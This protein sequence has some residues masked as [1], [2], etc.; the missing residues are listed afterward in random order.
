MIILPAIDLYNGQAVRL[1]RGD[2][3]NMTVYD[4]EPVNTAM[5]FKASGAEWIHI[6]DLEGAKSGGTPNIRTIIE[7]KRSCSLKCETGGGIRDI[8][9]IERYIESGI[10]RVILGTS[11]VIHE[12]FAAEAVKTFGTEHVAVGVDIKNGNVAVKGW[13]EDSHVDAFEFC[14]RMQDDGVSIIICTDISRD[15][16]MKGTNRELYES[17]QREFKMNIIASGG[18]S[19]LDDVKALAEMK[20]YGAIIGK[21]YYTGAID[22]REAIE[23]AKS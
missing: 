2:Y 9:T 22:L 12:G 20:L 1:L 13:L 5:K 7:I 6:V 8:K 14:K 10:D 18:V 3:D 15:G 16:A 23:A 21:A 11:A 17:M 19:T 4:T